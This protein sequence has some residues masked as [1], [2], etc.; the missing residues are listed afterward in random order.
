MAGDKD[1][2][3]IEAEEKDEDAVGVQAVR[4][5][6]INRRPCLLHIFASDANCFQDRLKFAIIFTAIGKFSYRRWRPSI[7]L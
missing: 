4:L 6:P 5:F 7:S 2:E 3:A 1:K